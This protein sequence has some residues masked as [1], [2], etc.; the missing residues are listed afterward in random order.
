MAA[1]VLAGAPEAPAEEAADPLPP[2]AAA[3]PDEPEPEEPEEEEELPAGNPPAPAGAQELMQA[4]LARLPSEP[5]TLEGTLVMRR[6]RGVV[7]REIPFSVRLEWG[8]DPPRAEYELRDAFGR[9]TERLTVTRRRDGTLETR[10]QGGTADD[11]AGPPALS[12]P[13]GGTDIT[14]LD[15]TLAFLWWPDA[16]LEGAE[17]FRGSLCDKV[18]VT[19]PAPV[20]GC[21]A[22]RLWID[23]RLRFIRQA[24]QLDD[25]G[26]RV[27]QM[28]VGSV[29]KIGD[30]WMIRT[31]EIER[32][33][34]GHRTKL[35]VENLSEG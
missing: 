34:T 9:V 10:R 30:R 4:V 15:L 35:R 26:R 33:G 17:E 29:G 14:W 12:D 13:V 18:T 1:I 24:E 16:R 20:P 23:R 3:A 5:L 27:R 2:P 32:P 19:P 7:L 8:A 28:W 21:A 25:Q 11:P 6:R 22:V 31:M